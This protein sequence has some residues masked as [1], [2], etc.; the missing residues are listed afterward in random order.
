MNLLKWWKQEERAD[1]STKV[2][3]SDTNVSAAL[4]RAL[5]GSTEITREQALEIPSINGAFKKIAGTVSSLPIK[6]YK[7][8]NEEVEEIKKDRRLYLLNHDT[9]DTL[10]ATQFWKAM[11]EDYYFGKGAYAYI[12]K[13]FTSFSSI[14]YVE[15]EHIGFMKNTNPIFKDYSIMV[16]GREYSKY[17]F[18]KILRNTKDG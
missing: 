3:D 13:E 7:E 5:M 11:L 2:T 8:S 4:L 17:D 15:N 9:G 12:N 6:L 10:T 16:D 14:H 1:T 18:L